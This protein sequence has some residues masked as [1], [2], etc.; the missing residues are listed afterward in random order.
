M[1]I[2]NDYGGVTPGDVPILDKYRKPYLAWLGFASVI[3][4]SLKSDT[5]PTELQV[6][7]GAERRRTILGI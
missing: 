2:S 1:T 7:L 5:L 6:K 3:L 4:S